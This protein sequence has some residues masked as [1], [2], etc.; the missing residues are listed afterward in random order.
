MKNSIK[1]ISP[2]E[3]SLLSST[4]IILGYLTKVFK[5]RTQIKLLF[6]ANFRKAYRGTVLGRLWN[7]L[8]PLV[9]IG[10]YI[11]LSSVRIIPEFSQVDQASFI[12]FGLTF[13]FL[14]VGCITQT[15]DC[16][17]NKSKEVLKTGNELIIFIMVG[18]ANQIFDFLVRCAALV[19]LLIVSGCIPSIHS[20]FL[21]FLV[22]PGL[23]FCLGVGLLLGIFNVVYPDINRI[24]KILL[25]YG[26]FLSGIIFPVPD[27]VILSFIN[28]FNPM[29]VYIT[30]IRLMFFYGQMNNINLYLIYS[31]LG[32]VMLF[33]GLTV[34]YRSETRL[35]ELNL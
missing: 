2:D 19:I 17:L 14:F 1:I 24:T 9:P 5:S 33:I 25:Q 20:I 35:R 13:W 27:I 31:V 28:F 21:P 7:F 30:E 32:I 34:L 11:F 26:L 23:F 18:F 10:I 15:I 22:L 16:I 4:E 29:H 8:L 12:C 6:S 3:R